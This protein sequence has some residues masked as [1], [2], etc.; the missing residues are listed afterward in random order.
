MM[1]RCCSSRP[2]WRFLLPL[3]W[4]AVMLG[5][6]GVVARAEDAAPQ[7]LPALLP[8]AF[9]VG[10]KIEDVQ[11]GTGNPIQQ[12]DHVAGHI[13]GWV[14]GQNDPFTN[15]RA[16]QPMDLSPSKGDL[17]AGLRLGLLGMRAG[18]RR[19]ITI[20]PQLGFGAQEKP[21]VPANSTLMLEVEVLGWIPQL[22]VET[23][24]EGVGEAAQGGQLVTVHYHGTL[25]DG[26]VFDSSRQRNVPFTAA[27]GSH[28]LIKGWNRGLLGMKVGEI[29]RLTIPPSLA[30]GD[31]AQGKIPAN[32]TLHFDIELLS[33]RPGVTFR[34]T[35]PGRGPGIKPEQKGIAHLRLVTLDGQV[36]VDTQFS[37]PMTIYMNDQVNPLGMY[38]G[39][40]GMQID[41]V[42]EINIPA[43]W[44]MYAG[45]GAGKALQM[46]VDLMKIID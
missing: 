28:Q 20:P 15:S 5:G 26:T 23:L 2:H 24:R 16:G 45:K 30:Y 10:L 8:K 12:N 27:L 11:E 33:I 44:G 18:G 34:T 43:Q 4:V 38:W 19:R 41:E 17:L 1:P 40:L 3:L 13:V 39:M 32:A 21:G 6:S 22:Q 29:R 35:K 37:K 25:D 14:V 42:R 7:D 31:R 46:T 36:L 9:A